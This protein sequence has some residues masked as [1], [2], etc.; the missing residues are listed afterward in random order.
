MAQETLGR[1][2]LDFVSLSYVALS[3]SQ[4]S[5]IYVFS[6]ST[7]VCIYR[8]HFW[9]LNVYRYACLYV[10]S[11][12]L[13]VVIFFIFVYL[14]TCLSLCLTFCMFSLSYMVVL[15]NAS[16]YIH[17]FVCISKCTH[18]ALV[19]CTETS[20]TFYLMWDNMLL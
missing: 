11:S 9:I 5:I 2:Y 14:S 10:L 6:I 16:T 1:W 7:Y 20:N 15:T 19:T 12:C 3:A 18:V 17:V 8:L 4:S 13:G